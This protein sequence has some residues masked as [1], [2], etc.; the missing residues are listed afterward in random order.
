MSRKTVL[1]AFGGISAEHEV[2]IIT[3]LQVLERIDRTLY[4]PYCVYIAKDGRILGYPGA[5]DRHDF[6]KATPKVLSLGKDSKGGFV[7][8]SGILGK[9]F[10]PAAA[11]MAFHG[12]TGEGGPV[13][14]LFETLNIPYTS[15][16]YESSVITMNKSIARQVLAA[17][18][19]PVAAGVS[20]F[21][22]DIITDVAQAAKK[23]LAVL[24]LPVIVK[25]VHFGSSI[26][27]HIAKTESE[28]ER[29]LLESAQVD[30]EIVVERLLT[31]F[32]EYN[33]SVR[34]VQGAVEASEIEA[35]IAYDAILSF[36]DKY[37]R[38]G[39]KTGGDSGMASLERDL[40]AKISDELKKRIIATAKA[41]FTSCRC[42]GMVRID[43]M[44]TAEDE[45][46]IT[47][48]NPIP[49]SMG[50]YLWEAKG[51][52]FPQQITD[53]IEQA[54]IDFASTKSKRLDY[55][56]DIVEKFLNG[57]TGQK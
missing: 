54:I 28:L 34:R 14:G 35:P 51:I 57:S 20:L 29:F 10:Y 47:E 24:S 16:S 22:A 42:K 25:P 17:D 26:G 11:Y 46:L 55:T 5:Q 44:Y 36:A 33:C 43:F 15:S 7:R 41:A 37:Q 52:S 27:I 38:G 1:V 9:T 45:L 48:I 53:L 3:G 18:G 49:G 13:Q 4:E 56:S 8:E 40:P 2:S 30:D 12:G 19:L 21:S 39:K 6:A 23:A 31:N 32:K 50:F